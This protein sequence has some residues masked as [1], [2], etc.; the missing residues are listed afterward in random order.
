[1]LTEWCD[2]QEVERL[3]LS[4]T[5][6][7]T[8]LAQSW[9]VKQQSAPSHPPNNRG[10]GN[11]SQGSGN[12]GNGKGS[13]NWSQGS[14][15]RGP[16]NWGN[17]KG[18]NG[19]W[20]NKGGNANGNWG[21]TGG[22]NWN[23]RKRSTGWPDSASDAKRQRVGDPWSSKVDIRKEDLYQKTHTPSSYCI[24]AVQQASKSFT[25]LICFKDAVDLYNSRYKGTNPEL[26]KEEF[27]KHLL[28]G[29]RT[30]DIRGKFPLEDW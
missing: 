23:D 2:S 20:E 7:L 3:N 1:M 26:R 19:N 6:V 16:G 9:P 21:N 17:A 13:G 27:R 14:G 18:G 5:M 8:S 25:R 24:F 10:S 11:W 22:G 15:N 12:W 4:W 28:E 30:F 29:R